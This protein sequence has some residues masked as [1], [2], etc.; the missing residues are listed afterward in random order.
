LKEEN[1][2]LKIENKVLQIYV[3]LKHSTITPEILK[4]ND[5]KG[6]SLYWPPVIWSVWSTLWLCLSS[7]ILLQIPLCLGWINL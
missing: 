5:S 3:I 2:I 6:T 1:L 7:Y 4:D